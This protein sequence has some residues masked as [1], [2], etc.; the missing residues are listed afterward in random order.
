MWLRIDGLS[1]P[2]HVPRPTGVERTILLR[3]LMDNALRVSGAALPA[4]PGRAEFLA[5][6]SRCHELPDPRS[7][8]PE[9]WVAVVARMSARMASMLGAA[10]PPDQQRDIARYLAAVS[11][12]SVKAP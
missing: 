2:F 10:L 9:D 4:D 3:Y 12:A 1:E 5:L 6:C 11:D 8:A 7:H